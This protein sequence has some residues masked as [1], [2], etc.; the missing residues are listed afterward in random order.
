MGQPRC[1]EFVEEAES[2]LQCQVIPQRSHDRLAVPFLSA[3][4]Q[5]VAQEFVLNSDRCPHMQIVARAGAAVNRMCIRVGTQKQEPRLGGP[6]R[7]LMLVGQGDYKFGGAVG[8]VKTAS[9]SSKAPS[10]SASVKAC[11]SLLIAT[12]GSVSTAP[13]ISESTS[14]VPVPSYSQLLVSA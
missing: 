3:D 8:R 13:S 7:G 12:A 5:Y 10:T 11:R 4:L 9:T 2:F 6:R 1:E 14:K